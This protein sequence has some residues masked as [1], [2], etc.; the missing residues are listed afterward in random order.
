[1]KRG[2]YRKATFPPAPQVEKLLGELEA[3]VMGVLW[4]GGA[5]TVRD[6]LAAVNQKRQR[7]VAYTTVMTVMS[8]LA[9]KGLLRRRLVGKT[10]H[11]EPAQSREQFLRESSR[12]VVS[13]LV[14]DFGEVAIVQFLEQIELLDPARI[15]RLRRLARGEDDAEP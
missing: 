5:T 7:P 8:R 1:M 4:E 13:A 15:E 14:A 11:Y 6:V 12:E 10:H 2:L 9:D 3:R